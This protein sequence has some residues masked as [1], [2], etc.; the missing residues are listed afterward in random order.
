MEQT[1]KYILLITNTDNQ[2][3][4]SDISALWAKL[5]D[6]EYK[7]SNVFLSAL[8]DV[9]SA[10]YD[11]SMHCTESN[12]DCIRITCTRVPAS[13][14]NQAL[15]LSSLRYVFTQLK[16]EYSHTYIVMESYRVEL[17]CFPPN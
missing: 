13:C 10:V 14:G 6:E 15:Y 1:E 7:K 5:A 9:P 17:S 3:A 8:I 4:L 11:P 12:P 16:K 2:I